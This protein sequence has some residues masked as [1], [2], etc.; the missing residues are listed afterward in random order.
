MDLM[1]VESPDVVASE[2]SGMP[3]SSRIWIFG[4]SRALDVGEEALLLKRVD[5]FVAHWAAHGHPLAAGRAWRDG[6]FLIVA[7]DDSLTPPSGCSTDSLIRE[8]RSL[9]TELDVQIVGNAPVWYRG[10]RGE[11]VRVTRREF[12]DLSDQGIVDLSSRVF[13]LSLTRLEDFRKGRFEGPVREHWH[14]RLLE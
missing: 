6:R 3:D 2:F 4:V 8:L 11:P 1:N 9:E 13:D 10:A 5:A 12:R 14:R 7:V